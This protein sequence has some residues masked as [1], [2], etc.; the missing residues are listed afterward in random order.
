MLYE[1]NEPL[2]DQL[3]EG[4]QTCRDL[5]A[6]FNKL[7]EQVTSNVMVVSRPFVKPSVRRQENT[8]KRLAQVHDLGDVVTSACT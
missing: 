1:L 3:L 6:R 4:S 2:V 8:L 5:N 7:V